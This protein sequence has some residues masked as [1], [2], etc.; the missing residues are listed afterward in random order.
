MV[1]SQFKGNS[2]NQAYYGYDRKLWIQASLAF[3]PPPGRKASLL[4]IPTTD[5]RDR[6][7]LQVASL[8]LLCIEK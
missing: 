6:P 4:A 8:T 7:G 1:S 5:N 2:T 3:Q